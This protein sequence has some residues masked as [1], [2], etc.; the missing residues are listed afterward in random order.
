MNKHDRILLPPRKQGLKGR[1]EMRKLS[2]FR[3]N[4]ALGRMDGL[5]ALKFLH[6]RRLRKAIIDKTIPDGTFTPSV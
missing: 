5:Q 4:M 2:H 3:T 6:P 1:K